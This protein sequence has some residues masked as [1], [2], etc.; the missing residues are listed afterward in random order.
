MINSIT[1]DSQAS[2]FAQLVP[3]LVLSQIDGVDVHRKDYKKVLEQLRK[4]GRPVKLSFEPGQDARVNTQQIRLDAEGNIESDVQTPRKSRRR[5]LTENIRRLAGKP[6]DAQP[7]NSP[8]GAAS[9]RKSLKGKT[10]APKAPDASDAP[11]KGQQ[12]ES[13]SRSPRAAAQPAPAFKID[14]TAA[15]KQY[16]AEKALSKLVPWMEDTEEFVMTEA[17]PMGVRW[18]ATIDGTMVTTVHPGKQVA[19]PAPSLLS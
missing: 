4:A 10:V 12:S 17:G 5:S 2:P 15:S 7:G 19:T 3:G 13:A 18:A 9:L 11:V 16:T 6:A 8:T 1:P 14:P